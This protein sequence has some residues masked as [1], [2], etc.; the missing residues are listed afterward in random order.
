MFELD[1]PKAACWRRSSVTSEIPFSPG[2][3]GVRERGLGEGVPRGERRKRV[4]DRRVWERGFHRGKWRERVLEG[5]KPSLFQ[6][7]RCRKGE[8]WEMGNRW[9][10]QHGR[11]V[12]ERGFHIVERREGFR[13]EETQSISVWMSE[14]GREVGRGKS[15]GV[16]AWEMSWREGSSDEREESSHRG[17]RW[18]GEEG[19]YKAQ[20]FGV[21]PLF[22][23]ACERED[24]KCAPLLGKAKKMG[25]I[26]LSLLSQVQPHAWV[27]FTLHMSW[28]EA[29][30]IYIYI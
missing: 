1:S 3:D 17:A 9:A 15:L 25:A 16:P 29:S 7:R 6:F 27:F 24:K 20:W 8:K 19:F 26:A 10:S 14:K 12:C 30:Y 21:F 2:T 22:L 23:F 11:R 13:G 28:G 5:R 4:A 18:A